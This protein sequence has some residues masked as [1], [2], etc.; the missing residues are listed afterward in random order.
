MPDDVAVIGFDDI[1]LA[2][3][4]E[5]PLTTV[6]QPIVGQGRERWPASSVRLAAGE[7]IEADT[8]PPHR[9]GH[10]RI[11]LACGSSNFTS[12]YVLSVVGWMELPWTLETRHDFTDLRRRPVRGAVRFAIG[13]TGHPHQAEDLLQ[14]ALAKAYRHWGRVRHGNPE[15]YLRQAMCREQIDWFRRPSSGVGSCRASG[16]QAARRRRH[17]DRRPAA[18]APPRPS[19]G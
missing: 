11:R 6:R 5:P 10:P 8:M 1:E 3:Y 19:A 12:A 18:R 17:R 4:T 2:R 7:D 13:L 16:C 14:S 15:A 9:T